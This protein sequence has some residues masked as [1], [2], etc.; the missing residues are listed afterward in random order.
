MKDLLRVSIQNGKYKVVQRFKGSLEVLRHNQYWRDETGD[1]LILCLAQEI[2]EL[3]DVLYKI[4]DLQLLDIR[5]YDSEEVVA[6]I[7]YLLKEFNPDE[8]D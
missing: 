5:S 2:D 4:Q 6:R 7:E 1:N 8:K 3:R